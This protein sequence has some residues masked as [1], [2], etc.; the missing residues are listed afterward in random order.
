MIMAK[1]LWSKESFGLEVEGFGFET[2]GHFL[3]CYKMEK[4]IKSGNQVLVA[5]ES[6][7]LRRYE[8]DI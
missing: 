8:F 4:T 5:K 3:A 1:V 7:V 6:R 2:G